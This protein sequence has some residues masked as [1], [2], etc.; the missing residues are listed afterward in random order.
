ME[1]GLLEPKL[2]ELLNG[3]RA[4]M[5]ELHNKYSLIPDMMTMLRDVDVYLT[6]PLVLM[7][8][9]SSP[10]YPENTSLVNNVLSWIEAEQA[11]TNTLFSS[12]CRNYDWSQFK[13]RG[14]YVSIQPI[15]LL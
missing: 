11:D 8:Q 9:T 7:Q 14:H 12:N 15:H 13:P 6:V 4:S 1:I 10:Y 2:I 5:P 3:L